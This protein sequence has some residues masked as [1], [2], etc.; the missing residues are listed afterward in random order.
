M[1]GRKGGFV[2]GLAVRRSLSCSSG[3]TCQAAVVPA[4]AAA[5]VVCWCRG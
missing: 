3:K 1:Y 5:A 4:P 2:H